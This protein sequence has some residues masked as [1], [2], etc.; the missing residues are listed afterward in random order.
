M[1]ENRSDF[2]RNMNL[3]AEEMRLGRVHFSEQSKK[4]V[5]SLMYV[6]MTPNRRINLMTINEMA[7]LTASMISNKPMMEQNEKRMQ[8]RKAAGKGESDSEDED[9]GDEDFDEEEGEEGEK[10]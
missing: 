1:I 3:L 5:H 8:R 7:R 4:T 10:N 9:F 2:E 6:R